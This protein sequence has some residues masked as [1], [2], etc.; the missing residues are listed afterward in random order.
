MKTA[1]EMTVVWARSLFISSGLWLFGKVL[2]C[3]IALKKG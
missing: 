3:A 1:E 2:D